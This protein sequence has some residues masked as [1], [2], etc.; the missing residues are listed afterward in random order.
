MGRPSRDWA[1][2]TAAALDRIGADHVLVIS[3]EISEYW[4]R[5]RNLRG[6]KEIEL[7]TSH[8]VPL[9]WMTALDRPMQVLQL[10]G[11]IVDRSGRAVRI[12]AEGLLARRTGVLAGA[13]GFQAL[14]TDD[15]VARLLD[16]R[17]ED[18]PGSPLVWE[19]VL[20]NLV[21]LLTGPVYR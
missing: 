18:L 2:G 8:T 14:I 13:A 3:V 16:A 12:G 10:T 15:E 11:A 1:E 20:E 6:E 17:R 4:P 7:G 21:S 5:Q 9:P 19:V